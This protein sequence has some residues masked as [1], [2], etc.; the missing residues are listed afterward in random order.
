MV[1]KYCASSHARVEEFEETIVKNSEHIAA[2]MGKVGQMFMQGAKRDLAAWD[3]DTMYPE[4]EEVDL[5]LPSWLG[6]VTKIAKQGFEVYN[7]VKKFIPGGSKAG[8]GKVPGSPKEMEVME[9]AD[10]D[11]GQAKETAFGLGKDLL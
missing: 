7:Q 6:S 11:W 3:C 8:A 10:I 2:T 5:G 4:P 1:T 9:L